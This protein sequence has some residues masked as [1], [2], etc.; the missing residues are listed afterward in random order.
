M[1]FDE[2]SMLQKNA[3]NNAYRQTLRQLHGT[4]VLDAE[5][6]LAAAYKEAIARRGPVTTIKPR[7]KASM[8]IRELANE[9]EAR[10]EHIQKRR[11]A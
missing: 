5:I 1:K 7:V 6:P 2:L 11:A 9:I 8:I 10:L 4:Q 3:V